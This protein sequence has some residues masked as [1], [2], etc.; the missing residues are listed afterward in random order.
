MSIAPAQLAHRSLPLAPINS[1]SNSILIIIRAVS[2]SPQPHVTHVS[3]G[4]HHAASSY[5]PSM[6]AAPA[7][8]TSAS[9]ASSVA[10]AA[11]ASSA[12]QM[13]ASASNTNQ[14][15]APAAYKISAAPS[16]HHAARHPAMYVPMHAAGAHQIINSYPPS[17]PL[18]VDEAGGLYGHYGNAYGRYDG[19]YQMW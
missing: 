10:A 5:M 14:Q 9:G 12:Q 8:P 2:Y 7:G 4:M 11:A 17:P 13:V 16:H 18:Y 1:K 3:H 19:G 15:V 6:I